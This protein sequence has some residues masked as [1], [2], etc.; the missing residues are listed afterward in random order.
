MVCNDYLKILD[1]LCSVGV[2]QA[3]FQILWIL[4]EANNERL[5]RCVN[6]SAIKS[7]AAECAAFILI[8]Q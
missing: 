8:K 6:G 7:A 5:K 3:A 4:F 1:P 2:K